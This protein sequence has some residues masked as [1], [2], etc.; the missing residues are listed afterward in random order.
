M[1]GMTAA[2]KIFA[3]HAGKE[4]THAGEIVTASVDRILLHDITGPL[5]ID[6]LKAMGAERVAAP[7]KVV[8]VG[9]HYSPPPDPAAAGLLSLMARF[10][11]ENGIPHLFVNGEGIE[12]TLL[13]ER[14][15]LRPGDLVIGTD[16]HTCTAGA[17]GA[18]G[19]GMGSSDIAAAMALDELWFMVP[20]TI[21]VAFSGK[22]RRYVTGKDLILRLLGEITVD[23]G[24]YRCI[25]FVGDAIAGL[26]LDERMALCNMAVEGGAKTCFVPP[27]ETTRS[28]ARATHGDA[29]LA[30]A[31]SSD[32]DAAFASSL[33]FDASALTPLCARPYSPDNVAPVAETSGVRIDQ[34]YI[35]NCANGTMTDLR[36]AAE[37]LAGRKIAKGV[38]CVVVPATREIYRQAMREGLLETLLDAGAIIAPSTCGACAGLHM[39]VL[40]EEQVAVATTNRNYRG[41]MGAASSRVYLANAYVAAASAVAGELID[42]SEVTGQ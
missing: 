39:G 19:T 5:A 4:R 14:G 28:W 25:E 8:L 1:G 22:R 40:G 6:Q 27:D 26:N 36:Q 31:V 30:A 35:G 13:P 24:T 9:D 32:E 16:S 15:L 42:P 37:I 38:R 23:G 3:A 2:E 7:D 41:R 17:F 10:A 29:G 12:H 20:E 21:R 18:L 11:A 33:S 34:A